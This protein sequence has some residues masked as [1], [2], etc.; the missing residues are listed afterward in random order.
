MKF[1]L[2]II[3]FFSIILLQANNVVISN[4]ELSGDNTV[5]YQL[6]WENSWNYTDS[7]APYNHDAVWVFCKGKRIADQEWETIPLS[8]NG[9]TIDTDFEIKVANSK[10]GAMLQRAIIGEGNVAANIELELD[11]FKITD[12]YY[13]IQVFAIE[14]VYVTE[15]AFYVGDSISNNTL[16]QFGNGLSYFIDSE[17]TIQVGEQP[18][19]LWANGD[20]PPDGNVD[21]SFPKGYNGFYSMKYEI[22]QHQYIGFLNTL[23]SEQQSNRKLSTSVQSLCFSPDDH[24][25]GERNFIIKMDGVFGCDANQN[26]VF[27]DVDD[28]QNVA[29]NFLTWSHLTAYLDWAGLRPMTELEYEKACRGPES[30][31]ELELAW[32]NPNIINTNQPILSA[33]PN[34]TVTDTIP[35]G[36]GIANFGYCLPSGPLRCGFAAYNGVDRITSG[37]S[38]FGMMEMSGN[39][40]ELC[41]ALTEEGLKF[42][43]N[44][45][46]GFIDSDG[47]ANEGNWDSIIGDASGF[48]GG[49]WN[50]GILTGFRD[51]AISDRFF[52]YLNGNSLDRGTTG[53]RGV[54]SKSMFE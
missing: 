4:L 23:N 13:E 18:G 21:A 1:S 41:I 52:A 31:V 49:G 20:F 9:N 46:D 7:I 40:W 37:A 43:G 3:L 36:S 30:A 47:N 22:S 28:G 25:D 15:G 26:S 2:S 32:G 12:L 29:C 39:L 53:G 14:M 11:V 44:H 24:I 8:I 42:N 34:E 16:M 19:Q 48:R 45:G 50:S 10:V 51:L 54:I 17:S 38:Y 5:K 27:G 33:E 6:S 35:N